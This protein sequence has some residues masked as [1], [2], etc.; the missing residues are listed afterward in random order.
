MGR[1]VACQ[2]LERSDLLARAS[3]ERTDDG[4]QGEGNES[5]GSSGDVQRHGRPRVES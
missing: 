3:A 4:N 5:R 1:N 2:R